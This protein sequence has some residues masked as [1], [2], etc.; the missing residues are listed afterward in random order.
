MCGVFGDDGNIFDKDVVLS[1]DDDDDVIV[2]FAVDEDPNEEEEDN[3]EGTD[4]C[5]SE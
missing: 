4:D 3:D 1:I 2:V 5:G